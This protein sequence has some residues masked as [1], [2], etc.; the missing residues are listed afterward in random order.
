MRVG[1][2][3]AA[4]ALLLLLGACRG[5]NTRVHWYF[6]RMLIQPYYKP[7]RSNPFYA[8]GRAM[9]PPPG[10]T[11]PREAVLGPPELVAGGVGDTYVT[12]FPVPVTM[13]LLEVG[14]RRFD[15]TCAACHGVMG[16]GASIVASKMQLRPPPSLHQPDI[17]GFPPGRIYRVINEGY[18]LMPSY[19]P[20]LTLQERWAVVAYVKALQLSQWAVV[21]DLPEP[22]RAE[23]ER[24]LAGGGR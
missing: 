1:G 23:V 18:G 12:T 17:R 20:Q 6:E 5:V 8:D 2:R 21:A 15:I 9:R 7:F 4:L 19:A 14:R 16:D 11:I 10:G 3:L 24:L 13:E 22:I